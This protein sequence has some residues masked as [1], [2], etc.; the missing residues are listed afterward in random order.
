MSLAWHIAALPKMK[1]FPALKKLQVPL[2]GRRK[3]Q[4]PGQMLAIAKM[5]AVPSPTIR[6]Q[7]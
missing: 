7:G 4:T 6:P 5:I 2:T 1:R 3:R